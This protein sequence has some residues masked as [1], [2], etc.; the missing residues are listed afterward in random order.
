MWDRQVQNNVMMSKEST[1]HGRYFING[2]RSIFEH[3]EMLD[4]KFEGQKIPLG[5]RHLIRAYIAGDL[6]VPLDTKFY[7]TGFLLPARIK[8]FIGFR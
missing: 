3:P 5:D 8:Y 6:R 4:S 7:V 2:P 1:E